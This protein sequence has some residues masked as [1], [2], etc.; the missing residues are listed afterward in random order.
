LIGLREAGDFHALFFFWSE[1]RTGPGVI[2][3]QSLGTNFAGKKCHE[4]R[5]LAGKMLWVARRGRTAVEFFA[6]ERSVGG[7]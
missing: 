7:W 1:F 5:E 4:G 6:E 3:G 2:L